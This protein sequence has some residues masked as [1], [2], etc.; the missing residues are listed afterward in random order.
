MLFIIKGVKYLEKCPLEPK[1]PIYLLVGGVVGTVK[2]MQTVI[3]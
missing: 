3:N 1:V 2:I